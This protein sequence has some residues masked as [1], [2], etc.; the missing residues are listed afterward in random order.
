MTMIFGVNLCDRIYLSGDTR[1]TNKDEQGN[2]KETKDC[3]MKVVILSHDLAVA[4]AGSAKMASYLIRKM[5]KSDLINFNIRETRENIQSIL[6]PI[7]EKYWIDNKSQEEVCFI[8][9]GINKSKKKEF[10][11]QQVKNE[12]DKFL[13][14]QESKGTSLSV[15]PALSNILFQKEF[16]EPY[17]SMV[18]SIKIAPPLTFEVNDTKWGEYLA[19]GS[20]GI[21][22]ENIP[23]YTLGKLEFEVKPRGED[24]L[25]HDNM[26]ITALVYSVAKE[27]KEPTIGKAVT[28]VILNGNISALI[29]GGVFLAN[30]HE[31]PL[32]AEH[33]SEIV[34][35]GGTVY[36]RDDKG[37]HHKL[38][39]L[40]DFKEFGKLYMAI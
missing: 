15:R 16:D 3:I 10:E 12:L 36:R 33:V 29:G 8:F 7:V 5:E 4:A 6:A 31:K 40:K 17:D 37:T 9:G 11:V 20:N 23:D 30:V 35:I 32:T 39:S 24:E 38:T 25:S 27:R 28:T 18:F 14:H 13:K 19:F 21:T 34:V 2:I 22:K 1:L 26:I